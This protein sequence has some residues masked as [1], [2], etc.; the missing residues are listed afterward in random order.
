[1]KKLHSKKTV[2]STVQVKNLKRLQGNFFVLYLPWAITIEPESCRK[3]DIGIITFLPTNSNGFLKSKF[4][5]DEINELFHGKHR[6][7]VEILN[8]SFEDHIETKKG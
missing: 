2:H 7:C 6:L 1:M 8:K 3:I 5:G 4:R